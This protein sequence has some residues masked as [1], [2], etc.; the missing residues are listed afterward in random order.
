MKIL[1]ADDDAVN[2]RILTAM[3]AGL[4]HAVIQAEDGT[5]AIALFEREQPDMALLDIVMPGQDGYAVAQHIKEKSKE[6]F[7]PVIFLTALTDDAAMRRGIECGADDFLSKPY[8]ETA[9]YSKIIAMARI[10]HIYKI[11]EQQRDALRVNHEQTEHELALGAH[12]FSSII[13]RASLDLPGVRFW[14]TPMS[15]FNGDLLIA[16][17]KPSGGLYVM[18]AD[19]T[20]HGLSAAVGAVPATEVFYSMAAKGFALSDILAELNSKLHGLLP[21]GMFC[22]ACLIDL[23]AVHGMLSVW[24]GGLPDML[25]AGP[26]GT[27]VRRIRST[28]LPLGITAQDKTEWQPEVLRCDDRF[29]LYLYSDGVIEAIN[30]WG[31]YGSERLEHH[32]AAGGG[33]GRFDA[34]TEDLTV[35]RGGFSQQDDM[36]LL[37]VDCLEALAAT[38][39]SAAPAPQAQVSAPSEWSLGLHME[40]N[41]LQSIDPLPLAN[42]F[43]KHLNIPPEHHNYICTVLAELYSNA[44]DHGLLGLESRIKDGADGFAQYYAQR[45]QRLEALRDGWIRIELKQVPREV[46]NTLIIRLQDSGPGFDHARIALHIAPHQGYSGRGIALVRSLCRSLQ[47]TEKGAHAEATYEWGMNAEQAAWRKK[48]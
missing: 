30:A 10:Q 11:V 2:R 13:Q 7:T 24:N 45:Q 14:S 23:D 31:S 28:H 26:D 4:G 35:F 44:L 47:Y 48:A 22:A 6:H 42:N 15:L 18:L 41:S 21:T 20:G 9:L 32:F 43:L 40:A 17:R 46:G 33:D 39:K 8:N 37:E 36:T 1:I 29:K 27:I 12:I 25:V 16:A 34:I 3:L 5:A 38:V 19:F